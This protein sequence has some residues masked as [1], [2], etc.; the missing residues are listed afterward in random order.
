MQSEQVVYSEQQSQKE[1]PLPYANVDKLVSY[2]AVYAHKCDEGCH[3]IKT[4]SEKLDQYT[5]ADKV[6]FLI[7]WMKRFPNSNISESDAAQIEVYLRYEGLF[8]LK[9][10]GCH[11]QEMVADRLDYYAGKNQLDFLINWMYEM[12]NSDITRR[13]AI[14]I[15][16]YL[17]ARYKA[18]EEGLAVVKKTNEAKPPEAQPATK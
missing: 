9:C 5:S 18:A 14:R 7:K 10:N 12:P 2:N 8:N 15:V 4:V 17:K 11:T 13:D 6:D 3:T 1:R 16:N